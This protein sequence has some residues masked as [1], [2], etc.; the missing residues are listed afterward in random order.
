MANDNTPISLR[1]M[2]PAERRGFDYALDC[3]KTWANQIETAMFSAP[4]TGISIPLE[5]QQA[6]SARMTR[7]LAEALK[8]GTA[9]PH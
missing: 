1:A 3:L 2:T 7:S 8:R 4:P 5:E 6:N 9:Q